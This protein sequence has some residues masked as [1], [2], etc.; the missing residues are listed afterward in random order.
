MRKTALKQ[1][2]ESAESMKQE[3]PFAR[4]V[5]HQEFGFSLIKSKIG[6]REVAKEGGA[7]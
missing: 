5:A 6:T 2:R 3:Q 1:S 7:L 4:R